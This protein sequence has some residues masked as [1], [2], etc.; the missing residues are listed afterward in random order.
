MH[1]TIEFKRA[2]P[3]AP[4]KSITAV[5]VVSTG[6]FINRGRH[7]VDAEVW[8]HPSDPI[9]GQSKPQILAISRQL[10][11]VMP[12]SVNERRKANKEAGSKL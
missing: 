11:L 3:Y 5:G 9:D 6:R 1:L 7:E 2:L 10:A 4:S 8:S 12:M